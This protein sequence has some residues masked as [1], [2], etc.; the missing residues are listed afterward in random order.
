MTKIPIICNRPKKNA[1][2]GA[3]YFIRTA[4]SMKLFIPSFF[5]LFYGISLQAQTT[6]DLL[7]LLIRDHIITREQADS[8]HA[9]EA[10]ADQAGRSNVESFTIN[11]C[12]KIQLS[13]FVHFR[14]QF[15]QEDGKA[16]G[17]DVRRVRLNLIADIT[18]RWIIRIQPDLAGTP[19]IIDINTDFRINDAVNFTF[20][21]QA[22]PFSLNNLTSNTKLDL[23]DRSQVVEALSSRKG[24]VLGDNSGRDIG[25]SVYGSFFP[26]HSR[27]LFDYRIG[28]FNGSG[29]NKADLNEAKDVAGRILIHPITGLDLGGS[30]YYGHT[31]DSATLNNKSVSAQLGLRQRE[32]FEIHYAWKFLAVTGEYITGLDGTVK[33]TGYYGQL[34]G[35]IIPQKLQIAGRYDTFDKNRD[36]T[37]D[38]STYYTF[39][40]NYFINANILFQAA[41][42]LRQEEGDDTENNYGSLQ[43]QVSF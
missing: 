6:N 40:L 3:I 42:S 35:T 32:G 20:G 26:V 23:A 43:L 37:G 22:I 14:Y 27:K 1:K 28:I 38:R 11:A 17:F 15:Q 33:K 25:I 5:L 24:D 18:P 41:Y 19:K 30:F 4:R 7:D 31:P 16:D 29:I 39:G 10:I 12:K 9:E 8:L 2:F 36:E 34:T 13:G 21:Q